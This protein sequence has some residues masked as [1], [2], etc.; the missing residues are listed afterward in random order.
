MDVLA[1]LINQQAHSS[2]LGITLTPGA[3]TEKI[4]ES[5]KF[6]GLQRRKYIFRKISVLPEHK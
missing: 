1:G 3:V 4:I 6:V 5:L 2:K